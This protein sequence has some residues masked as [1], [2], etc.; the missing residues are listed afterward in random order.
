MRKQVF[1]EN[2]P[3]ESMCS[4]ASDQIGRTDNEAQRLFATI[5]PALGHEILDLPNTENIS[6]GEKGALR[7]CSCN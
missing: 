5:A 3:Q 7:N 4:S 6:T 2:A 1:E